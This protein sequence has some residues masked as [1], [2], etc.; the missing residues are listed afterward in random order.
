MIENNQ[1]LRP[2]PEQVPGNKKS[3]YAIASFIL[4][5]ASVVFLI[6]SIM[7]SQYTASELL[8][9]G[10]S[11]EVLSSAAYMTNTYLSCFFSI[12]G[13]FIFPVLGIVFGFLGLKS[14]K[15]VYSIL[16]LVFSGLLIL[17][18]I[19][20]S[21]IGVILGVQLFSNMFPPQ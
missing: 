14:S 6:I 8:K 5:C 19:I 4:S 11:P 7:I 10:F 3:S 18:I 12:F 20:S 16:G 2:V 13:Y 17:F 9:N 15:R 21:I 1:D